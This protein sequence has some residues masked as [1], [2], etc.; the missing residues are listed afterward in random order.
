MRASLLTSQ[1]LIEEI[2]KVTRR[3]L[4]GARLVAGSVPN[5]AL[6]P[7]TASTIKGAEFG[8]PPEDLTRT[9]VLTIIEA[10][11]APAAS[12]IPLS[13]GGGTIDKDWLGAGTV[14]LNKLVVGAGNSLPVS[15]ATTGVWTDTAISGNSIPARV[16]SGGLSSL[17][18]GAST[19]LGRLAS[20]NVGAKTM[21]EL[22]IEL[23]AQFEGTSFPGSPADG[24]PFYRTDHGLAYHYDTTASGWLS[25]GQWSFEFGYHADLTASALFK[26]GELNALATFSTTIGYPIDFPFKVTGMLVSMAASGTCNIVAANGAT[27]IT[28]ANLSLSS[29]Q[30]KMD[31]AVLSN[32]VS[33]GAL[34]TAGI[35]SGT[36]KGP[37]RGKILIRRF[38]T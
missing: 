22:W 25:D 6:A 18:I 32:A 24:D 3:W 16:G 26:I 11:T 9:Q 19:W 28:G 27:A 2:R 12:K 38:E 33:A 5:A 34:L 17:A 35:D 4:S 30:S 36:F 23:R 37:G 21:A 31:S 15:N 14:P 1:G 20:G 10:Q 29:V 8:G 7:M 13:S